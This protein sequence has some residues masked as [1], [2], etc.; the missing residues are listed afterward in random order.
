LLL[1]SRLSL[2][3]SFPLHTSMDENKVVLT[4][5]QTIGRFPHCW[6]SLCLFYIWFCYVPAICFKWTSW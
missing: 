3:I 1:P 4:Q 6:H 5:R 2:T